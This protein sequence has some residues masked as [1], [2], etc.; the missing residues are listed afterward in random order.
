MP[1]VRESAGW[2]ALAECAPDATVEAKL[3][4]KWITVEGTTYRGF[5]KGAHGK[6]NPEVEMGHVRRLARFFGIL[7]RNT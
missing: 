4:R 1:L 5:P 6:K 2:A 7:L 3:H